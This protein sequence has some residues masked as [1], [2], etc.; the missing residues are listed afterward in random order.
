MNSLSQTRLMAASMMCMGS[1]AVM[2]EDGPHG[3]RRYRVG[4]SVTLT[5]KQKKARSNAKISKASKK[6][7]R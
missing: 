2:L 1:L 5:N 3:H 6:R 4:T 7:N